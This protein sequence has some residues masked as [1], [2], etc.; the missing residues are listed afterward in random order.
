M[1]EATADAIL[2]WLDADGQSRADGAE[3]EYYAGQGLPCEPRNGAPALLEE[4]LLIRGVGRADLF[5][6]EGKSAA[7]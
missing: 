2:D 7:G 4:L 1:S 3:A 6:D 5:G